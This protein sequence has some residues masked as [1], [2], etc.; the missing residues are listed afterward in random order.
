VLSDREQLVEDF[1][2]YYEAY[3][4]PRT[5]GRMF[6]LLLVTSEARLSLDDIAAQ[7][8]VSK[9]SVSTAARQLVT[10]GFIEKTT[11]PGDRRDY[12]RVDERAQV[13]QVQAGVAKLLSLVSLMDRAAALPDLAPPARERVSGIQ[14]LYRSLERHFEEFF[15]AYLAEKPRAG[16]NP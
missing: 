3:G 14:D 10:Y 7:L 6:A 9:A 12:Y 11:V 15:A 5:L 8:N 4:L 16:G 2:L 13:R 1:G